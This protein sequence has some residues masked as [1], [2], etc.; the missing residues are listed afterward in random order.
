SQ[1]D[2]IW[3]NFSIAKLTTAFMALDTLSFRLLKPF[4]TLSTNARICGLVVKNSLIPLTAL[5]KASLILAITFLKLS[6][7]A[8]AI[9]K[10]ATRAV[11]ID[12]VKPIG[13]VKATNALLSNPN[14]VLDPTAAEPNAF[15]G[16]TIGANTLR[17]IPKPPESLAIIPPKIPK[18]VSNGPSATTKPAVAPINFWYLESSSRYHLIPDLIASTTFVN[19]LPIFSPVSAAQSCNAGD[20]KMSINSRIESLDFS[21]TPFNKFSPIIPIYALVLATIPCQLLA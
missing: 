13:P 15:I 11:I 19:A 9:V 17:N 20:F 6:D 3:L 7:L 12:T 1:N 14:P 8:Y 21:N 2:L 18:P 10:P 4:L 5:K 16:V